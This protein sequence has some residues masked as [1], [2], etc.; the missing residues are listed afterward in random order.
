MDVWP[1]PVRRDTILEIMKIRIFSDLHLEF[2]DWTPPPLKANVVVLAGDI[3]V[4]TR[5]FA[6]VRR[7]FK[8]EAIV[9]VAGNH[10]YFGS[11]IPSLQ[12]RLR[13]AAR[14]FD[15]Q[16]L[17]S[18]SVVID[19]VRFLGTTLWTDFALY[20][21]DP[22][23]VS[24]AMEYAFRAMY[25]YRSIKMSP[26]EDL[27]PEHTRVMH[28]MQARWLKRQLDEPFAG[29]TVVVTHHLPHP[30]SVHPIY[31]GERSNPAFAS[32]LSG[33]FGDRVNL[34]VHG[35]THESMDYRLGSTRVICNPRGY[36]P[37]L[38]NL[39]FAPDLAAVI[40]P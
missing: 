27:L 39:N 19:G 6:W 30:M 22:Q 31:E 34:W 11:D 32:D 37:R 4:G 13:A 9:Y 35:H 25:D 20:G 38:P 16:Y 12:Q 15:V 33:L 18:D 2:Q 21:S 14:E 29:P 5:A 24:E 10:E 3:H 23:Q 7:H 1:R 40:D 26:Q 17:E 36:L 28:G 8:S